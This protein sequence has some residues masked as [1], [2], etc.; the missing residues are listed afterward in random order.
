MIASECRSAIASCLIINLQLA[1]KRWQ[2]FCWLMLQNLIILVSLAMMISFVAFKELEILY[3]S[4]DTK[5][6]ENL[7][8]FINWWKS[9]VLSFLISG[10]ACFWWLLIKSRQ[11]HLRCF[12]WLFEKEGVIYKADIVYYSH[13]TYSLGLMLRY[14]KW[15]INGDGR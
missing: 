6:Q 11:S 3:F 13:F 14:F 7:D 15:P 12:Y 2:C 8:K 5:N 4:I 9:F 10:N 1:K